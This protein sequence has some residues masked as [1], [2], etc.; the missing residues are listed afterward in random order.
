MVGGYLRAVGDFRRA[1][2]RAATEQVLARLRGR[3]V[4]LLA[5]DEVRGALKGRAGQS[6]G[7][8][9]IPLDAI[10]GSVGRYTDFTRSFLP[11][12]DSDEQRWARVQLA[13]EDLSGL[14]P[15]EVY[16][17]GDA[18]FVR[19]GNHR[20]S[21]AR[22]FGQTH[23]QANVTEI[24]TRV[25]LSPDIQPQDLILKAQ[26]ADFLEQTGL[27]RL[28][29]GADLS[30]TVAWR[31]HRLLDH[32]EVHRFFMGLDQRREIPYQEAVAHWYDEVYLPAVRVI[33]Q[34][35]ML[36]EFPGRTEADLYLWLLEHR[37][38]LEEALGWEVKTE[39]AAGNLSAQFGARREG[40]VARLGSRLIDR[41]T[42]DELESGPSAGT[43]RGERLGAHRDDCLFGEILVPVSGQEDGWYA[44]NQA[45]E[46]AR[47]EDG[48]LRG[49]HVVPDEAQAQS[50]TTMAVRAKFDHLCGEAGVT[51]SLAVEVGKISRRI[52][53][54]AQ[55]SDLVAVNLAH[56][57]APQ[58][59][60]RLSSGFRTLIRRCA[61]PVLAV[62]RTFS[63]MESP[64]LAFDGSP[65]AEEA[66]FVAAY[67]ASRWQVS[68]TIVTVL[69]D[70]DS[71]AGALV[72]ARAYLELHE[73]Q[74]TFVQADGSV[75]EA[76]LRTAQEHGSDLILMGGYGHSPVV[77]VVLGST[78]DHVL[79]TS[80][81][82]T[83]V[84]R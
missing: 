59:V 74:A 65:K 38:E 33:R 4:D 14:P 39:E 31:Y 28:R 24:Q 12:H 53:E 32:I 76:I 36:R 69:G 8:H 57:P 56:P 15:I 46:I 29:P 55:W 2:R 72:R 70:T 27:D 43:W 35:G 21:V 18:F 1:R 79:R 77:E 54:R 51:G 84:C 13:L 17:I 60:A 34:R 83:L 41:V 3:S 30:L 5:F 50:E 22:Q 48:Q 64:L 78:V 75:A 11:R 82:P 37:A 67:L 61:R 19:D 40:V 23:I 49:L 81:W 47:R 80:P 66:L 45:L 9:D 6:L 26:Y 10:V 44:F 63:A 7:L 73:V 52:C 58:A 68:L 25:T 20:V 16:K 62:P 42:P 71:T